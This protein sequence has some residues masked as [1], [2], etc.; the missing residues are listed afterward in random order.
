MLLLCV[1]SFE[2]VSVD[3]ILYFWWPEAQ[4][5]VGHEGSTLDPPWRYRPLTVVL[6]KFWTSDKTVSACVGNSSRF[7]HFWQREEGA[8]LVMRDFPVKSQWRHILRHLHQRCSEYKRIQ[9]AYEKLGLFQRLATFFFGGGFLY[10]THMAYA[11]IPITLL[12]CTAGVPMELARLMQKWKG[13][14]RW[15]AVLFTQ[16]IGILW[17][18]YRNRTQKQERLVDIGIIWHWCYLVL[19]FPHL[20]SNHDRVCGTEF[21][22]HQP[23]VC[24]KN[25]FKNPKRLLPKKSVDFSHASGYHSLNTWNSNLPPKLNRNKLWIELMKFNECLFCT[26]T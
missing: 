25:F 11:T 10:Q 4:V 13:H 3:L 9:K 19:H 20:F 14:S 22:S 1:A 6:G 12:S 24:H 15:M 23:Q 17:V 26:I 21:E 7:R 8:T 18:N 2:L 16:F 5:F